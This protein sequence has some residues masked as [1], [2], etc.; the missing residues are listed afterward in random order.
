MYKIIETKY[1]CNASYLLDSPTVV[2]NVISNKIDENEGNKA[3][4]IAIN[5]NI[6]DKFISNKY[7]Y[8]IERIE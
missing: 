8:S 3:Y 1:A 4:N 6:G 7:S 5:L 2:M